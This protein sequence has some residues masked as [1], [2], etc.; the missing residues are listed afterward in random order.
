M[1][2]YGEEKTNTER[3]ISAFI[4]HCLFILSCKSIVVCTA[5]AAAAKIHLTSTVYYLTKPNKTCKNVLWCKSE[6]VLEAFDARLRC[7]EKVINDSLLLKGRNVMLQYRDN[8]CSCFPF[9][10]KTWCIFMVKCL[11]QEC[12]TF[13]QFLSLIVKIRVIIQV[14][15]FHELKIASILV[16]IP[17]FCCGGVEKYFGDI[18]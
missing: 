18:Y 8:I 12:H 13:M 3:L 4:H 7:V 5:A 10:L 1:L 6:Q 9:R 16:N 14:Y 17:V 2:T 11:C 15:I